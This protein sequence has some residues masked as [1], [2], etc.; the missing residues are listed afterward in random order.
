[1][2]TPLDQIE[3]AALQL[4]PAER[5]RLAER[6]LL[7]LEQ[8][9]EILA[10]WGEEAERRAGAFERGEINGGTLDE[11]LARARSGLQPIKGA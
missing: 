7:S 4:T 5:A 10:A 6:L 2:I 9:D 8:D 3:S 11:V 1:M